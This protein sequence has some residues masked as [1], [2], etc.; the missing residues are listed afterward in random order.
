MKLLIFVA[1]LCGLCVEIFLA[2]PLPIFVDGEIPAGMI[3]GTNAVFSLAIAPNP[4]TSLQLDRNGLIQSRPGDFTISTRFIRFTP[5]AI[6][7]VGDKLH[8]SYRH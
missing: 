7:Q 1:A 5:A 4:P 6:P 3:D 2:Q 8:A